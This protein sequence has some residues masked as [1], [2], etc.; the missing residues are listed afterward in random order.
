MNSLIEQLTQAQAKAMSIKPQV[1]G[2]PVLAEVL[3]Q[4]GVKLN[5][6]SLPSC[7][8]YYVM[9]AGTVLQAGTHLVTGTV[10]VP[11]FDREALITAIRTDQAGKSS[12]PEFLMS[13]WNAG[14]V[15]FD[16]DFLNRKVIYCGALGESYTESY[17]A[18]ELKKQD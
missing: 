2:F 8:S 16:V 9:D 14:V 10:E 6:W 1:G 5:R 11:K 12:F 3:R 13:T 17:P 4:A 18:V 15:S 7:Q